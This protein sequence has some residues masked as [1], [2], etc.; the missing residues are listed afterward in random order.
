M[1]DG[2][3]VE[4][5][6]TPRILFKALP[7]R[8]HAARESEVAVTVPVVKQE[9][10]QLTATNGQFR[11]RLGWRRFKARVFSLVVAGAVTLGILSLCFLM[12]EV[13]LQ[14]GESL[15]WSFLTSFPSRFP[16]K[17]GLYSAFVG[18]LWSMAL[19]ALFSVPLGVGAALYLEEYVKRGR[20][21]Q[22]IE[23]N[24]AN[25][26]GVPSI[27]YG[28]LG[29][30]V[31]VRL[32]SL[33]RSVIAGSLTLTLLILPVIIVASREALRG[34]PTAIRQAAYALGATKWQTLWAHVLPAA[35]PGILTGVILSLSRAMGETA[36]LIV[37][38]AVAYVAFLPDGLTSAFTVLPIQ[39]YDW[40]SRPQESF[41]ALAAGGIL[42][43]LVVLLSMNAVAI[44][45]RN[46][47][48]R[49]FRW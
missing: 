12:M 9:K 21:S 1:S 24:I 47:Y 48:Q 22:F 42:V 23:I 6:L 7:Q 26:A 5:T 14:G 18:T 35:T 49:K 41:H 2:S 45:I 31:F 25:L 36:P 20:L 43:L 46:R 39:I 3:K 37:I 8:P 44:V 28:L 29:L 13:F 32:A 40:T 11:P 16:E 34:V 4:L 15:S 33:G 38:G 30:V 10:I 17:A 19:T 27:I